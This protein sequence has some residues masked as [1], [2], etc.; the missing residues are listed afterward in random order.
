MLT[1]D[2][3]PHIGTSVEQ[4]I[5]RM[6]HLHGLRPSRG[7][8]SVRDRLHRASCPDCAVKSRS[9]VQA[10]QWFALANR[11][12]APNSG[13]VSGTDPFADLCPAEKETVPATIRV[14][15]LSFAAAPR[16]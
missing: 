16:G 2:R 14:V 15:E 7:A 8:G 1:I 13:R 6:R 11:G 12:A 5:D 9:N 4:R 3:E 10:P